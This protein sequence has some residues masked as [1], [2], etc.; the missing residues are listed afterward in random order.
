VL[1]DVGSRP[2]HPEILAVHAGLGVLG[3]ASHQLLDGSSAARFDLLSPQGYDR[4]CRLCAA[5]VGAGDDD[6]LL[7]GGSGLR[8]LHRG[9]RASSCFRIED[10]KRVPDPADI[11]PAARQQDPDRSFRREGSRHRR[12]LTTSHELSGSDDVASRPGRHF[13][14]RHR[15][16]LRRK[17][18]VDFVRR[19]GM[20][21]RGPHQSGDG[22][23]R[24]QRPNKTRVHPSPFA[25]AWLEGAV[26]GC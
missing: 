1:S 12:C 20:G 15:E 2:Y 8:L 17:R 7:F 22:T 5:D 4:G 24:K 11:K 14:E 25:G 19:L 23:G 6:G 9:S 26:R 21:G 3:Q 10:D 18:N 13:T 16:I